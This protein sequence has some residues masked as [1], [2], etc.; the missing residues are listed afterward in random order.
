MWA[1][2]GAR[3][4]VLRA[5]GWGE[6]WPSPASTPKRSLG[7]PVHLMPWSPDGGQQV[8]ES[9]GRCDQ[10]FPPNRQCLSLPPRASVSPSVQ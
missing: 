7:K 6:A 8:R 3:G 1:V 5:G 4:G 9:D 10:F 2:R